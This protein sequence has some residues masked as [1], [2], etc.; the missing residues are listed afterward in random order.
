[1][2]LAFSIPFNHFAC[3]FLVYKVIES[4][5]NCRIPVQAN[6]YIV[7]ICYTLYYYYGHNNVFSFPRITN[8]C[9]TY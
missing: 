1:M 6:K 7:P 3:F 4:F 8:Y 2:R 9:S 5:I